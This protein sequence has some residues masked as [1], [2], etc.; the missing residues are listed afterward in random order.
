MKRVKLIQM[1]RA[2][3]SSYPATVPPKDLHAN[4][5]ACMLRDADEERER[6]RERKKE[7]NC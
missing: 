7:R 3:C 1:E 4:A 2:A 5:D 6:E